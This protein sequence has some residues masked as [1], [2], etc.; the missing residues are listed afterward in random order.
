MV[1]KKNCNFW[2]VLKTLYFWTFYKK[3]FFTLFSSFSSLTFEYEQQ[4]HINLKFLA[5]VDCLQTVTATRLKKSLVSVAEIFS[6]RHVEFFLSKHRYVIIS[7]IWD[8]IRP[9]KK[10]MF[11][12][13]TWLASSSLGKETRWFTKN[14]LSMNYIRQ[15]TEPYYRQSTSHWDAL[16]YF[17]KYT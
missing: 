16:R 7:C 4:Y 8:S 1:L 12:H 9:Y 2:F 13:M 15:L 14:I 17:I 3:N 5:L 10:N 11:L 6:W